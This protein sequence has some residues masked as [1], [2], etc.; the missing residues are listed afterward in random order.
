MLSVLVICPYEFFASTP[1]VPR[2]FV[3]EDRGT[4]A[5]DRGLPRDWE[6]GGDIADAVDGGVKTGSNSLQ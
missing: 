5:P 6:T 4:S 3:H 1:S 2:F